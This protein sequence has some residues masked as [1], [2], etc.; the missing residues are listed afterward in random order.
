MP[1]LLDCR[2]TRN[3]HEIRVPGWRTQ[4]VHNPVPFD[5][6]STKDAAAKHNVGQLAILD[7]EEWKIP[8]ETDKHI[9]V[10]DWWREVR[11]DVRIGFYGILPQLAYWPSISGGVDKAKWKQT[12]SSLGRVRNKY[13]KWSNRGLVDVVDFVCPC[14]YS[15]YPNGGGWDHEA[16]W[17]SH[18]APATIEASRLYQKQVYPFIWQRIQGD[19]S[20]IISDDH[21][22]RQIEWCLKN[23]DGVCVWDWSD[24]TTTNELMIRTSKIMREFV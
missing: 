15:F 20:L 8:D 17:F 22:R 3:D 4:I 10:A 18:Y 6:A 12:N 5:E 11:P 13:G 19:M 23:A 24:N 21:F 1:L 7:Y 9:Q 16:L 2:Q 14:L